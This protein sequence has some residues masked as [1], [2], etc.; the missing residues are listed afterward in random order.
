MKNLILI[1][2]M[3][4][5]FTVALLAQNTEPKKIDQTQTKKEQ[6]EWKTSPKV[7]KE[8]GNAEIK[9]EQPKVKQNAQRRTIDVATDKKADKQKVTPITEKNTKV[10][11]KFTK[12]SSKKFDKKKDV[13][14]ITPNK[15]YSKDENSGD[16]KPVDKNK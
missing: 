12:P 6:V 2:I 15:V 11:N 13:N 10:H 9:S 7:A 14:K 5:G 4:S 8:I 3:V 1:L 16:I